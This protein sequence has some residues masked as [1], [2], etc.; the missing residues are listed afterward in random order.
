MP[1]S[2]SAK[3]L[4]SRQLVLCVVVLTVA[5]ACGSKG[6]T[7]TAPTAPVTTAP[8]PAVVAVPTAPSGLVLGALVMK[9]R[10]AVISWGASTGATEYVVELGSIAG[11]TD[12]GIQSIAAATSFTL[13]DLP[14]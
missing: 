14:A 1:Q 11:G 6:G 10:T 3:C 7:P 2:P 8:P 12:R 5:A 9:D 13:R 4:A